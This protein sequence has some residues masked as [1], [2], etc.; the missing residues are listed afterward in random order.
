METNQW[1][2]GTT[3][4][5]VLE[6]GK[7]PGNANPRMLG[8]V[9][10]LYVSCVCVVWQVSWFLRLLSMLLGNK[11]PH[12]LLCKACVAEQKQDDRS[13]VIGDWSR[14]V[15]EARLMLENQVL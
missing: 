3:L 1:R 4:P 15:Y 7:Q 10:V 9:V 13:I 5:P 2:P 11:R 14:E 12:L 8:C 6:A